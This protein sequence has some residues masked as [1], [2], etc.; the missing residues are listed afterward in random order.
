MGEVDEMGMTCF[1]LC[2]QIKEHHI[3]S[4]ME[5]LVNSLDEFTRK[6]KYRNTIYYTVGNQEKIWNWQRKNMNPTEKW[7]NAIDSLNRESGT[8]RGAVLSD[9]HF[10]DHDPTAVLMALL[11]LEKNPVDYIIL[12]GDVAD[13][14]SLSNFALGRDTGVEDAL[15]VF[16]E[17]YKH[18]ID[19]IQRYGC[20]YENIF[21]LAGNHD[22][23]LDRFL[24]EHWQ[25]ASTVEE[26]FRD[27]IRQGDRVVDSPRYVSDVIIGSLLI[28]HGNRANMHAA[29]T[30]LEEVGHGVNV[31]SGHAHRSSYWLQRVVMGRDEFNIREGVVSGCL[32]NLVPQYEERHRSI[33]KKWNH[34]I[35]FTYHDMVTGNTHLTPIVFQP[36]RGDRFVKEGMTAMVNGEIIRLRTVEDTM[37]PIKDCEE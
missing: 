16:G 18:L 20:G 3:P 35:V 32:C 17:F 14:T 36:M 25:V 7:N 26:T 21:Y 15:T 24:A 34:G 9:F 27:M 12:N 29:K 31:V 11:C 23:R 2:S 6:R 37:W 8:L 33:A 10:P 13:F 5:H 30:S 4:L 19:S 28:Q 1:Q 22:R